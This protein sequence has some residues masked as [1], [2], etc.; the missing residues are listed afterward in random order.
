[1][2]PVIHMVKYK[3]MKKHFLFT[4][5][6]ECLAL[7]APLL[8]PAATRLKVTEASPNGLFTIGLYSEVKAEVNCGPRTINLGG[9][10]Q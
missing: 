10:T 4:D 7:N 6:T 3:L 5:I 9:N 2:F 8:Y 1:M